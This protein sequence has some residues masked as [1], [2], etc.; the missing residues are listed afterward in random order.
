MYVEITCKN[1]GKRAK[2]KKGKLK[3][4]NCKFCKASLLNFE[5][6][7]AVISCDKC[8]V[9]TST[10]SAFGWKSVKCKSCGHTIRHPALKNK[11]GRVD[12]G[13]LYPEMLTIKLSKE[14]KSEID[15]L[16]RTMNTTQGAITRYLLKISLDRLQ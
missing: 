9:I 13:V 10:P 1:C 11:G 4:L 16:S 3:K 14:T 5:V 2:Y 12:R 8:G 15:K 6:S 7:R